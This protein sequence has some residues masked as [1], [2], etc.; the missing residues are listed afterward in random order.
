VRTAKLYTSLAVIVFFV[1]TGAKAQ[2]STVSPPA[3][4][5]PQI[6]AARKIFISNAGGESF[7]AVFEQVTFDGGPDR[8]YNQFYSAMKTWGQRDLVA[9]PSDADLVLEI[10][11]V[12]SDTGLKLPVLGQLRLLMID[13]K[14]HIT[15]WNIMEYVRGAM[16]LSNRNKNFD[17]AMNLVVSRAQALL[18]PIQP[19]S[20]G[21][22]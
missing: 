8:A 7:A 21:R 13:P 5:P 10:N 15:L 20:A 11:W 12:L 3:P 18:A 17:Q 6:A 14:T 1:S 4:V 22:K 2:K 16:L 19:A 9:S